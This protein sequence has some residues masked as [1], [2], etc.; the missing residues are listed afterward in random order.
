MARKSENAALLAEID[1]RNELATA[2]SSGVDE[3]TGLPN[4]RTFAQRLVSEAG[5]ARRCGQPLALCIFQIRGLERVNAELGQSAGD[6]V[7]RRIGAIISG[8]RIE[9]ESFRIGGSQ[10]AV[11][12]PQTLCEGAESVAAR[13]SASL[14]A[15]GLGRG[16]VSASFGAAASDGDPVALQEDA[17]QCLQLAKR[18]RVARRP[19]RSDDLLPRK[20][21]VIRGRTPALAS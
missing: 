7:L 20:V 16:R 13:F 1:L 5:R 8:A 3:L 14:V 10:F 18:R 11:L 19:R 12:M 9:D 4:R 21:A 17:V 2:G 6:D 15:A